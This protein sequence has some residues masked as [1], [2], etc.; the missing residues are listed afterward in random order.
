M[1]GLSGFPQAER[2]SD[3]RNN[4]WKWSLQQTS[5]I[6]ALGMAVLSKIQ[7]IGNPSMFAVIWE[8]DLMNGW[9][10]PFESE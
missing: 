3:L 1:V 8:M 9:N 5:I 6:T 4:F 7:K 2:K 10:G